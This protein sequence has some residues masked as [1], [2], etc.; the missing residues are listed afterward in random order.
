MQPFED[1]LFPFSIIL[2]R[3]I[4]LL[5][6]PIVHFLF[7]VEQYSM[8]E[9]AIKCFNSPIERH[10][11]CFQFF[12]ITNEAFMNIRKWF[13][14]NISFYFPGINDQ[15]FNHQTIQQL[16]IFFFKKLKNFLLEC[17][18]YTAFSPAMYE[19]VFMTPG[20]QSLGCMWSHVQS[21]ERQHTIFHANQQCT[22]D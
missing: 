4:K 20:V 6:V 19:H 11:G 7:I 15:E 1:E 13:Y 9:C 17:L 22:S 10:L 21:Y 18:H 8:H 16:H 2:W 14:V 3:F 12:A 5:Y